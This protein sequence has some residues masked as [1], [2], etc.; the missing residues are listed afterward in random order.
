MQNTWTDVTWIDP[1]QVAGTVSTVDHSDFPNFVPQQIVNETGVDHKLDYSLSKHYSDDAKPYEN[2]LA[3][4]SYFA[5]SRAVRL[6]FGL[7][8]DQIRYKV[9]A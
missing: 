1:V 2:E 8:V 5:L 7:L 9:R 4:V 6:D 3:Q